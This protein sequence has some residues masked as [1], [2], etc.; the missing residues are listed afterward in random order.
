M[1]QAVVNDTLKQ[2]QETAVYWSKHHHTIRTMFAP[3][4]RALIEQ[5]RIAQGQRVLDVAG[6]AGEPSLTIADIVGP[7]GSVMCTDPIAE[8]LA[9]AEHEAE[10]L[11]LENVQFRQCTADSLPF[12]DASFDASVCRLGV[13]FFPDPLAGIR[14]MLRVTKPG[15]YVALAVW[16]KSEVNPYSYLVTQVISR[17]VPPTPVAPNAPD[18]FRFCDPGKLRRIVE[19]AGAVDAAERVVKFDIVAP[20]SVDEFWAMRAEISETLRDKLKTVSDERKCQIADEVKDA[21]RSFF[22]KGHM[23]FPAQMII[24]SGKKPAAP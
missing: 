2:W 22:P 24:V 7:R 23:K 12:A 8:M 6:G 10:S 15:G 13:M 20:I 11:G 14:E 17:H 18:A 4:T 19:D 21:A 5:A 3:L 9:A 1:S 16:D